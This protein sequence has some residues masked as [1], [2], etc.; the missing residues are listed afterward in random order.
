M[1]PIL[2]YIF[3]TVVKTIEVSMATFRIVLITKGERVKGAIVGFFEVILWVILAATVLTNITEDPLKVFFYATG[4]ALGNFFGSMFE[5]RIGL[6]TMKIE[7]IVMKEHGGKLANALRSHGFAVTVIEGE[8]MNFPRNVLIMV[9]KRKDYEFVVS[10]MKEYQSNAFITVN[11]I[12]PV[13]GG[14]GTIKK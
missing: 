6:G 4:F 3:I 14:F 5:E 11:E 9:V 13:Y 7:A 10:L 1:N 2:I 8:G 12:K